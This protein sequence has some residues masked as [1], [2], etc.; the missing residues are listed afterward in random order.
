MTSPDR[1]FAVDLCDA[2][3][4]Q[5]LL[6]HGEDYGFEVAGDR[7]L[8]TCRKRSPTE[9]TSLLGTMKGFREHI[10]RVVFSLY[11]KPG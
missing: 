10:P 9:L 1:K 7:L 11:P 5:W 8:A 2:R 3:M 4:M 6:A